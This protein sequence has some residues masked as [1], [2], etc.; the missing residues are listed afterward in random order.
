MSTLVQPLFEPEDVWPGVLMD[1]DV[2]ESF[3]ASRLHLVVL[4]DVRVMTCV[5]TG[6]MRLMVPRYTCPKLI[7]G[8]V[9][10]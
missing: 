1:D 6:S 7:L 9:A 10:S 5:G 8:L 2:L 3:Q 4:E